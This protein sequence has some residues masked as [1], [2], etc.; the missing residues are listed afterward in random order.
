MSSEP[1]ERISKKHPS[2]CSPHA[3]PPISGGMALWS[4]RRNHSSF[5]LRILGLKPGPQ[6][7][8][9]SA[10]SLHPCWRFC[11][12]ADWLTRISR[13]KLGC[14]RSTANIVFSPPPFIAHLCIWPNALLTIKRNLECINLSHHCHPPTHRPGN[15]FREL[16]KPTTLIS[17]LCNN[18]PCSLLLRALENAWFMIVF[19]S[20][21]IK[22]NAPPSRVEHVIHSNLTLC[23]QDIVTHIWLRINDRLILLAWE[24]CFA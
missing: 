1:R 23:S 4:G 20:V 12:L 21:T 17:P 15:V 10:L 24:L 6:A 11:R 2:L 22:A 5:F 13:G 7:C 9:A 14:C 16:L 19:C 18:L 8:Y 3:P